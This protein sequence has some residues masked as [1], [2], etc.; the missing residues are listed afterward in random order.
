LIPDEAGYAIGDNPTGR[1]K[2][3][4][5]IMSTYEKSVDVAVPV[6]VAYDQWTQ[7]ETFPKFMS[8]VD[9]ITQTSETGTHWVT[10]IGGVQR[11]FDAT[12]TEQRPDERV[13]WRADNGPTQAGVVTF[14]RLDGDTTRVHLQ[15]EMEP[16]GVAE[17]AGAVTGVIGHQL[18]GDLDKFK[19]FIEA[20][21]RQSGSWRGTVTPE[22]QTNQALGHTPGRNES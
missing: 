8:G 10:S 9:Q 12:I 17:R 3:E 7:F 19:D 6:R 15:L 2:E 13:A 4:E 18:Q 11:E 20:Q 1:T 16:E 14:H 22:P 21:G 5:H